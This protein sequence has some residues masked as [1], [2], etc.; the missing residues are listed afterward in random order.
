MATLI[1]GNRDQPWINRGA[2][3]RAFA[4]FSGTIAVIALAIVVFLL[5]I[6]GCV[7]S[8]PR[9]VPVIV[10]EQRDGSYAPY[11][12]AIAP[13]AGAKRKALADWV[14]AWRLGCNNSTLLCAREVSQM[15]ISDASSTVAA[16]VREYNQSVADGRLVVNPIVRSVSGSGTDFVVDWDEHVT[17][18]RSTMHVERAMRA[19]VTVAYSQNLVA[20]HVDPLLNPYGMYVRDLRVVEIQ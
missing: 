11:A 13:D 4:S 3:D 8:L 10:A 5:G 14:G 19:F 18:Q 9:E 16:Q 17:Q 7:A 2:K 15:V 12:N 1:G 6:L 20:L